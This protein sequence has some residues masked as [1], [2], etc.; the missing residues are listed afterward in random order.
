MF[1]MQGFQGVYPELFQQADN[2]TLDPVTGNC[3]FSLFVVSILHEAE[4]RFYFR[5]Y[6]DPIDAQ[7]FYI[8]ARNF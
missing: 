5:Y 7:Q 6:I 3:H 4:A 2:C 8:D 1:E